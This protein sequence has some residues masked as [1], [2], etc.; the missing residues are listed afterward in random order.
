MLFIYVFECECEYIFR[1]KSARFAVRYVF[2][3]EGFRRLSSRESFFFDRPKKLLLLLR[4]LLRARVCVCV[5]AR[6]R[7]REEKKE[8]LS[9]SIESDALLLRAFFLC[10]IERENATEVTLEREK[11]RRDIFT[12]RLTL[13]ENI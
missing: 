9:V 13:R 2:P 5:R 7:V 8:G 6:V 11:E 10:R 12:G 1:E 4:R 3:R